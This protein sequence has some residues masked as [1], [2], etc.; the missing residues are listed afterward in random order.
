MLLP[1]LV[2]YLFMAHELDFI[3]DD[4]YISYRYAANYLSGYGLVFNYGEYIEGFTNFGWVIY[5]IFLGA[6]KLDYIIIS[7]VT[8]LL[9]GAG[10]IVLT[11]L[12]G[13]LLVKRENRWF[14][15]LPP[16]LVGVSWAMAYWSPAG[17]ET[18]AFGFLAMLSLYFYLQRN[19]LLIASLA[20]AV[21]M[22]PE[23]AVLTGIIIMVELVVNRRAPIFALRCA[24][25]ALVLSLPFVIFKLAYYGGVFPN[26]FYAKT[27]LTIGQL[28]NGLEYGRLFFHQ[29]GFWGAGF[30]LPI[31]FFK[32]LPRASQSVVL[33]TV[34]YIIYIILIGGD[35]LKIQR[36]FIPVF[37]TAA[38]LLA[39]SLERLGSFISL[40]NRYLVLFLSALLFIPLTYFVPKAQTDHFNF[41]E[42]MFTKKMKTVAIEMRNSDSTNFSVAVPTIGVF[43]YEL[44]GHKIIDML[45]LTDSTIARHSEEP[46][47]GMQT[48]WKETKHNSRYLLES[49]P[50]Y[51]LFSTGKKPSAP[52]ERALL[53]YP[54]F[55]D[56][57]RAVGWFYKAFENQVGGV[58]NPAFKKM[59]EITGPIVPTYPVAYV[60]EYKNALDAYATGDNRTSILHFRKAMAASPKPY[61]VYLLYQK[62]FSHIMLK[63]HNLAYP[64][65]EEL[66]ARDS[67]MFEVHRELYMYATLT[68]NQSKAAIHERWI[69]KLT[70]W[71]WPKIKAD[72][73]RRLAR[74]QKR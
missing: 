52:A 12:I 38:I 62:A 25:A 2:A 3:Q 70:P 51:I 39:I 15:L 45:G 41:Y 19:Y 54:Q 4:A 56:C 72:I 17:L 16:Y 30:L 8:G 9:C 23:G 65:L 71:Y 37:G 35:V 60:Q 32:R 36:F 18:A 55:M 26:P 44:L 22:R 24:A 14:A 5:S 49:A 46:I 13:L 43:G 11:Y 1:P 59:R 33:Y 40:K 58:I 67:L 73:D 64:I 50:D 6:L 34:L 47:K 21:W 29:Y 69:K 61:Y 57:Y 42:V 48:T 63:E 27:G 31:L 74:M 28:T 7:R 53:L 68:G 20:L 10:I 66:C